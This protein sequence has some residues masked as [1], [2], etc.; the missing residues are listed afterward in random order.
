MVS[1]ATRRE[2]VRSI[3]E[4]YQIGERRA[5]ELMGVQRSTYR[6]RPRRND[7]ELREALRRCASDRPRFGYRRLHLLLE[8]E[9]WEVNIKRV[10]R[11][12]REEGLAVRRRKR[13][14]IVREKRSTI[15]AP[16]GPNVQ[17]SMDF[18]S[19]SLAIGGS[20]RTLN[21][22]DDGTREGLAMEVDTSITGDRV[23][24]VLDRIAESRPLP[25]RI[26]VDN[27]PEFTGKAMTRWARNRRVELAFIQ[28]GRPME[29]CFVESFNG[30]FR[31]EC[32]NTH[33][34]TS[35]RSAKSTIEFWRKDYNEVRPHS[36]LDG[37]TPAEYAAVFEK[38]ETVVAEAA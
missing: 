29:N 5:C 30:R 23:A 37:R 11:I 34:F 8:R 3:R 24:R 38:P 33:W 14:K 17:W 36:S 28:P 4:H 15:D 25:Q 31:D 21:I 27:G 16:L 35:L 18:V 26:V 1:L 20:F 12:Y 9:G 7:E 32:L 22:I 6:Y 2:A 13:K 19:D 10:H